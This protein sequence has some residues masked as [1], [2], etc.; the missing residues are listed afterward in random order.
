MTDADVDGS[1]IRTLLLTFFFRQMPE[2]IE[3]GFLYIAQPPLF[4]VKRGT[5]KAVY[6]KDEAALE[7]YLLHAPASATRSS[8][9]MTA[10]SAA[11]TISRA[12]VE[13]RPHR[14][15]AAAALG[16]QGGQPLRRRTGGDRGHSRSRSASTSAGRRGRRRTI[17]R[18]ASTCWPSRRSAAGT[19]ASSGAACC[20]AHRPWRDRG[21][22]PRRGAAAERRGAPPAERAAEL[23][24]S[25]PPPASSSPRTRSS[26][27]PVRAA[28]GG[29]DGSGPKDGDIQRYKGLGEMNPEQLWETTL[30]P[31]ARTLLQ[32]GCAHADWPR[33]SSRP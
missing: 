10:W 25:T 18:A 17:W 29:G 15:Q 27:S 24:D 13:R 32:V 8:A 23:A 26:S 19:A 11:R 20:R 31:D 30:D 1:H 4:Q 16:A 5:G 21:A 2:L 22:A 14:A 3:K 12:L 7:E 6:L 28:C 9:S 33:R